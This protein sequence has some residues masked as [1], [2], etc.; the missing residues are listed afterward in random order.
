ML[1]RALG[2][3]VDVAGRGGGRAVMARFS[4]RDAAV[5]T[6]GEMT[7]SS[8]GDL[9][10]RDR[11]VIPDAGAPPRPMTV[12]APR[13][14]GDHMPT[15]VAINGFGRIGRGVLPRRRT[16]AAPTSSRRRQRRHR[17]RDA[18]APARLRLRLRAASPARSRRRRDRCESTAARSPRS[19]SRDPATLPWGDAR[20][21]RRD[22]VDRPLP[23]PRRRRQHLE[24]GARKVIISAPAK[25]AEP[26]DATSC[27]ASTTTSTTPSAT[28]SSRTPPARRTASRPSPRCCTRRSASAT[29][30]MTTIHAYTADQNLL[31]APHKDLRRARAAAL[32]LIPTSTGAAK[33]LGL[34]IPELAGRLH[35]FAVRVPVPTGSLVDLTVEAERATTRRGDQRR[36]RASA[37]TPARSRASSPTARTRSSRPTSSSR[38]TRRSSTRG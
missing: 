15:R 31:D 1:A 11:G 33:A 20:R 17:R 4:R 22:R 37:P 10:I 36:L 19:P 28:T 16:S 27:S 32:N 23:H 38:R 18:R 12:G 5:R 9:R 3:V 2:E 21:R 30:L 8:R 35:G 14:G 26:A 24:A 34:V 29:A 6:C 7:R 25:G 13:V